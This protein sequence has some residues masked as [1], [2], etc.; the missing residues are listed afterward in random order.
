[1]RDL[2]KRF[3]RG[4]PV[5]VTMVLASLLVAGCGLSGQV[6]R[7][8]ATEKHLCQAAKSVIDGAEARVNELASSNPRAFYKE[9]ERL[10]TA[11]KEARAKL[12]EADAVMAGPIAKLLK[13]DKAKE[14]KL[15]LKELVKVSKIRDLAVKMGKDVSK[16]AGKVVY[17]FRNSHSLVS[18]ARRAVKRA[19]QLVAGGGGDRFAD[20]KE[21]IE[22][23]GKKY[24]NKK[25]EPASLAAMSR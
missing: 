6:K 10:A 16:R 12:A 25:K 15:V 21:R 13:R 4:V 5:V 24:P 9:R 8:V 22:D 7:K 1:M 23:A 19:N 20:L 11:V 2:A 18:R 3:W 17:Y 14:G